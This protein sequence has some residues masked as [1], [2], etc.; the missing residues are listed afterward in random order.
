M[1]KLF[2]MLLCV[3]LL[4]ACGGGGEAGSSTGITVNKG[5]LKIVNNTG[6]SIDHVNLA[7]AASGTWG[8]DQLS[9][10]ITNGSTWDIINTPAGS[11]DVKVVLADGSIKYEYGES[12]VDG[13][14]TTCAIDPI[15]PGSTPTPTPTPTPTNINYNNTL[16]LKG[17]WT[18]AETIGI[19]LFTDNY[20]L[21]SMDSTPDSSG[22]YYIRGTGIYG[23]QAIGHY[24]PSSTYWSVF[25][26]NSI[27][28]LFYFF[29]TDGTNVLSGGCYY[30]I[31]HPSEEW[32]SCYTL[33]GYKTNLTSL[34]IV[35]K[36]VD[37]FAKE[38]EDIE[39]ANL[40]E[41]SQPDDTVK[42]EYL[43]S[44]SAAGK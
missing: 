34:K 31:S 21:N 42:S 22:N 25:V 41:Y 29:K 19:F 16:L 3:L 24:S 28:D 9:S 1:K 44:R 37:G 2:A 13:V 39:R 18:F 38:K 26:P 36:D 35:S 23:E 15:V 7:V 33:S 43:R 11:Y 6:Q 5:T 30:Q 17:T 20:V 27:L 40:A 10:S 12:V 14:T 4:A 32:S 8:A